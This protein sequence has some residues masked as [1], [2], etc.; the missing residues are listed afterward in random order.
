MSWQTILVDYLGLSFKD[1][2]IREDLIS[3]LNLP[4]SDFK[5]CPS[6]RLYQYCTTYCN[7]CYI[8]W[9][10]SDDEKFNT[11]CYIELTGQGCRLVETLN[12]NFDWYK[13][14]TRYDSLYRTRDPELG[15]LAKI[16]RLDIAC[17]LHDNDKI[18]LEFLA[19]QVD[20]DKFKSRVKRKNVSYKRDGLHVVSNFYIGKE[21]QSDRYM[22]VYDKALEQREKGHRPIDYT[23][24]WLRFEFQFKNDCAMSYYLNLCELDGDFSAVYYGVL[25]NLIMFTKEPYNE[26]T[27]ST[28]LTPAKWWRDFLGECLNLSQLYLPGIDYS[29]ESAKAFL[30][31]ECASTMRTVYEASDCDITVLINYIKKAKLNLKQQRALS[32]HRLL[33]EFTDDENG[34]DYDIPI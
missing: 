17:D 25:N 18:T 1:S 29:V 23:D 7:I 24:K 27:N 11:G 34:L 16:P 32:V 30:E 14:L 28:R 19:E 10:V 6:K 26:E 8:H 33:K 13:F 3:Y 20:K 2:N 15:Y 21:R 31:R 22:R 12:P 4:I 5:E 9:T